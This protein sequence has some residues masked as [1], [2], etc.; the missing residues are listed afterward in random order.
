[1]VRLFPGFLIRSGNFRQSKT[2]PH[3]TYGKGT[4][5]TDMRL[6]GARSLCFRPTSIA[7]WLFALFRK[8]L[9]RLTDHTGEDPADT[10]KPKKRGVYAGIGSKQLHRMIDNSLIIVLAKVG[11]EFR[12]SEALSLQ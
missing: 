9:I 4:M 3:S 6:Q 5:V 12:Y 11:A 7:H 1:M 2:E 8:K 10:T